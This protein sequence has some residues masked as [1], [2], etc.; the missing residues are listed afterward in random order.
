MGQSLLILV[1][2]E[3]DQILKLTLPGS[4]S[5][6]QPTVILERLCFSFVSPYVAYPCVH[7]PQ[8]GVWCMVNNKVC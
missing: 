2:M 1:I 8:H 6:N 7:S 5:S 4:N 3:K